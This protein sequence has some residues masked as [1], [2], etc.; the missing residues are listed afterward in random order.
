ML[1]PLNLLALDTT[2]V[3]ADLR[4]W[5]GIQAADSGFLTTFS[6]L[7]QGRAPIHPALP[8]DISGIAR[9]SL[10]AGEGL[11]DGG[12]ALPLPGADTEWNETASL[13]PS[14][15]IADGP[16]QLHP[17]ATREPGATGAFAP[18]LEPTVADLSP[19]A[20]AGLSES[21]TAAAFADSQSGNPL[22][23]PAPTGQAT[24]LRHIRYMPPDTGARAP[25]QI[26]TA[27]PAVEATPAADLLQLPQKNPAAI[28][29][30]GLLQQF[31]QQVADP[32]Q[33]KVAV[34][35]AAGA[36]LQVDSQDAKPVQTSVMPL[37]FA[38]TAAT[39]ASPSPT[40]WVA[41]QVRTS[42]GQP[43]WNEAL[44]ERV[45]WMAGNKL[46]NAELKLNPA[47][48]GPVRVQIS[49]DDG[50]ATVNFTAQHPLT[51]DAIEQALPRLREMLADQGLSL[52]NANVSEQG[53]GEE[54]PGPGR[55][56][57][58]PKLASERNAA[59][60][61]ADDSAPPSIKH[62]AGMVDLFA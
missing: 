2:A 58:A 23:A 7:R 20:S 21:V 50:N 6:G 32:I 45:T 54:H 27:D 61:N 55:H 22:Q 41:L 40:Q 9:L 56:D 16:G 43:D 57:G 48:L 26:I 30:S 3:D 39:T 18:P 24:I 1:P 10:A 53:K 37:P 51:R 34:Q 14:G 44:G 60:G 52:Q 28:R 49:I 31:V 8:A 36:L 29:D 11:P 46:Q 25:A 17:S 4:T 47:E 15:I 62:A 38:P 19:A 42:P 5:H 59:G 13:D 33:A 35:T 12:K